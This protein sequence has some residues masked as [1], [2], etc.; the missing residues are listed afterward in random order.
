[1]TASGVVTAFNHG[2]HAEDETLMHPDDVLG[3]FRNL[4]GKT[5]II[6]REELNVLSRIGVVCNEELVA[7]SVLAVVQITDRDKIDL[8]A[9][10]IVEM[11]LCLISLEL[12]KPLEDRLLDDLMPARISID[13]DVVEDRENFPR[14][15]I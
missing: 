10:L 6:V 8:I 15:F 12:F 3:L 9:G 11:V 1:M 7:P 2:R 4:I 13:I 14:G 5:L